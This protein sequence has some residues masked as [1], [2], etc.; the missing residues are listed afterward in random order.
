MRANATISWSKTIAVCPAC[1]ENVVGNFTGRAVDH[2]ATEGPDVSVVRVEV[3]L[4]QMNV[5]HQCRGR[6][7]AEEPPQS[8]AAV[9]PRPV[10]NVDVKVDGL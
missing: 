8:A 9:D 10:Q 4:E 5:H 1:G 6:A 2:E 7:R 3:E